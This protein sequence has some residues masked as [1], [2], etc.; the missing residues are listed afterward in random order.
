MS[1][2]SG[3]QPIGTYAGVVGGAARVNVLAGLVPNVDTTGSSGAVAGGT[4]GA[5]NT[6]LDEMSPACAVQLQVEL[7]ALAAAEP[8][9]S[10]V[11]VAVAADAAANLVNFNSGLGALTL[12]NCAV[13]VWRAGVNVT[14]DAVITTP[15]AGVLRIAN[16]ATYHVTTGDQ[17]VFR[18]ST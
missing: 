5:S 18:A 7:S 17:I 4:N 12:T 11:Y 3:I 8:S 6:Y 15:S 13:T 14:S 9:A 10:Q 1:A 16:G 2:T